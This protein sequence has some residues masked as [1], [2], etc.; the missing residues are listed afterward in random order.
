MDGATSNPRQPVRLSADVD[1]GAGG[2]RWTR[3]AL[4]VLWLILVLAGCYVTFVGVYVWLIYCPGS[5]ELSPQRA[6][7]DAVGDEGGTIAMSTALAVATGLSFFMLRRSGRAASRGTAL[8]VGALVLPPLLPGLT[9][10]VLSSPE[11][12]CTPEQQRAE[13]E[14]TGQANGTRGAPANGCSAFEGDF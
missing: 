3:V 10:A 12:Y 1:A 13:D 7:C 14:A 2:L 11:D 8:L 4:W 5:A 9:F 6:R